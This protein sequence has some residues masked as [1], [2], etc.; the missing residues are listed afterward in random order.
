MR[1]HNKDFTLILPDNKKITEIKWFAVYDL[2][3]QVRFR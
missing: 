3:T 2:S 1:Y